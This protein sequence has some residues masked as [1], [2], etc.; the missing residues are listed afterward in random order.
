MAQ[1]CV[2]KEIHA[3]LKQLS[4]ASGIPTTKLLEQWTSALQEIMDDTSFTKLGV[5]SY[6]VVRNGVPHPVVVTG[7]VPLLIGKETI[8]EIIK[9]PEEK[10]DV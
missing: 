7:I 6:R 8:V 9:E 10:K 5:C 3:T 2:K 4:K 1:L